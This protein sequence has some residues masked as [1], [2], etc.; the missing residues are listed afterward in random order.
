MSFFSRM[1]IG[2]DREFGGIEMDAILQEDYELNSTT[3]DH[4]VDYEADVTDH[5]IRQ[6]KIYSLQG[7]VTDT[8]MGLLAALEQ[9]GNT[10]MGAVNFFKENVLG[11]EPAEEPVARSVAAFLALTELWEQKAVFDIQTGMGLYP[12]MTILNIRASVNQETAGHLRFTAT[13]RQLNRVMV[14]TTDTEP[15]E[16]EEGELQEGGETPKKE[17]LKQKV[18]K[19]AKSVKDSVTDFF[20]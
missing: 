5:I 9:I 1:F 20:S 17:G 15:Q 7:V 11:E 3:T 19:L 18:T 13:L 14:V 16:L 6:P 12:D 4:P 8:P 2:T 10:V